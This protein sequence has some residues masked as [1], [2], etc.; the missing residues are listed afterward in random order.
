MLGV[1][2]NPQDLLLMMGAEIF[3]I[4]ASWAEKLMKTRVQFLLT[5]SVEF[6]DFVLFRQKFSKLL[7]L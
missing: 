2:W 6:E 1:F 5:P 3:K 7:D 4:E